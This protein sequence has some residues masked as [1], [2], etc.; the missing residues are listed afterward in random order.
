MLSELEMVLR[1]ILSAIIGGAIGI[2]REA[3][4]RPAGFRTHILVSVGSTLIML[5]SAY[6]MGESAD[7]ARL[8]A[9]VV[10]GIGFLG[11]GTI[12]RTGSHIKGLT[13]AASLWVCAGIGLAIGAGFY[14]G[15][16]V[17][18]AIVLLSLVALGNFEV[19]VL[20]GANK[21]V[22]VTATDRAGLIG[23]IGTVL[24]EYNISIRNV[25]IDD[26]KDDDEGSGKIEIKFYVKKPINLNL[27]GLY[28]SL[29]HIRDIDEVD[30]EDQR[31][32]NWRN[33]KGGN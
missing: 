29:F 15:G 20:R 18:A 26:I 30:F 24:G 6:G 2:E 16:V 11:A 5:V 21:L 27:Q 9:Q 25:T 1:L 22:R 33:R 23:D 13:T 10:S 28:D 31:I 19:N 32:E 8:A 12:L 14:L 7:P 4:N 17:T 3:S